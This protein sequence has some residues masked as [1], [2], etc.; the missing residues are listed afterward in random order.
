[1]NASAF[2]A[3]LAAARGSSPWRAALIL[4]LVW[5]SLVRGLGEPVSRRPGLGAQGLLA[6]VLLTFAIGTNLIPLI[7]TGLEHSLQVLCCVAVV[8]GLFEES[9][10]G[11]VP[12]WLWLALVLAPTVRCECLGVVPKMEVAFMATDCAEWHSLVPQLRAFA[13]TLPEGASFEFDAAAVARCASQPVA[14]N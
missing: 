6:A 3:P 10:T 7:F 8:A 12:A 13:R 9:D 1:M 2:D 11:R 14:L 4:V 5:R